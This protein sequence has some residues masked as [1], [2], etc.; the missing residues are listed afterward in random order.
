M[1]ATNDEILYLLATINAGDMFE[2][3]PRCGVVLREAKKEGL[4]RSYHAVIND[5]FVLDREPY[6]TAK[7][8][9]RLEAGLS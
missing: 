6:I 2:P 5:G 8:K 9:A 1:T 3:V 4:I 7:G